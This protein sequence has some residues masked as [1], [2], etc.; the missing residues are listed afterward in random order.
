MKNIKVFT[1]LFTVTTLLSADNIK[2]KQMADEFKTKESVEKKEAIAFAS[3]KNIPIRKE[4]KDGRII[5]IQKIKNNV[6]L[7]YTT[8]NADAAISTG[9]DNLWTAPFSVDGTGYTNLGEWDGGAVLSTHDELIGRITQVDGA[10]TLSNHATHVAGTLIASGEDPSAKGMAHKA[11][12]LAYDWNS[13]ESEMATAASNGLEMSNH[14]YGYITGWDGSANWYGDTT[15]SNS[16]AYRFGFYDNQ[17]KSWD[18]IA[19][20]APHYL[21][22][23]AAGNDRNDDAP[24]AG[25]QHTHNGVGTFTDNHNSDGFDNGGYDTISAAAIAKNVLTVG[26]V[27]DVSSYNNP[28]DVIMSSFS[29]WGPADDGRIKP[30][31][32]GNGVGL[33]SSV[34]SGNSDYSSYSGTSMASPNITGSLALLQQYYKQ[35]HSNTPMRSATLKAL[36]IHTANES[37][38]DL[39]PDYKFGWGLVNV[40][41]AAQRIQ[42]DNTTNVIDELVLA[43]NGSYTRNINL[44]NGL[45][46]FKVTLA[47]TDPSG[48][49]VAAVLDPIDKMLVND[50]D[51]RIVKD[52]TTYYPWKLDENNPASAATNASKNDVDNVEQVYLDSPVSGTYT[53]IVDHAGTLSVDQNFSLI[54]DDITAGSPDLTVKSISVSKTNLEIGEAY[55]VS[56]TVKNSGTAD[57]NSTTLKYYISTDTN[58]TTND[59][60]L[61]TDSINSLISGATSSQSNLESA[62]NTIGTYYVGACVDTVTGESNTVNNCSSAVQITVL[63]TTTVDLLS[64]V[65]VSSSVALNQYDYYKMNVLKGQKIDVDLYGLSADADLYVRSGLKPTTA[66]FDCNSINGGT[67]IEKCTL[68]LT[69][70]ADVYIGVYGYQA[71]N[72]TIKA[73]IDNDTDG[74]GTFDKEDTDD[75]ND[76]VLDVNDAFPLDA[77]ESVD[78]DADGI[79]NNTDQ[80]D[81]NDGVSDADELLYG[82][83][84]LN[85]SDGKADFDGDGFSNAL[86]ISLGSDIRNASI[87]PEWL[88]ISTDGMMFIIPFMP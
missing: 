25:T 45:S 52:G 46:S 38:S 8:H 68:I 13:D 84:P 3:K 60:L 83:D 40:E 23:K 47:W 10:T 9:T 71:S 76:G 27:N 4:F 32:V 59:T 72:Y 69:A 49:P 88:P 44:G 18:D 21:I 22:V 54:L 6:P 61:S 64:D 73:S 85:A 56:A 11:T 65:P 28:N 50:L 55:T 14:S 15:I 30:D 37:G 33:R 57:A 16:E 78:T 86:E 34:A 1:V 39:G 77:S 48:T 12:L 43:N 87:H 35:T 79:G 53:I 67:V 26:A 20:N 36:V 80:D 24:I 63:L 58:I 75:D 29:G 19:Y 62:P 7:Y 70:T 41:K 2:L 42:E 82:L 31:I 66:S 81:D 5:E 51:I 74:D 17:A